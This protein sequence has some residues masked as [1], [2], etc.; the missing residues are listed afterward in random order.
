MTRGVV[1]CRLTAEALPNQ[2]LGLLAAIGRGLGVV[3]FAGKIRLS[4]PSTLPGAVEGQVVHVFI[5]SDPRAI[6]SERSSSGGREAPAHSRYSLDMGIPGF[7][8]PANS[9]KW[10]NRRWWDGLGY[11]RVRTLENPH[12]QRDIPWLRTLLD[13]D[14]DEERSEAVKAALKDAAQVARRYPRTSTGKVA[15]DD[16]WD[17][18]LTAIDQALAIRQTEHLEQVRTARTSGTLG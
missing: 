9:Q 1:E 3:Q 11:L 6:Q 14:A 5:W 15:P 12:W 18:L 2:G 4:C 16:A 7:L 10:H 8:P 13:A 17:E